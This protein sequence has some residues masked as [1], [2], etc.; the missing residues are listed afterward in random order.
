MT[1]NDFACAI[2]MTRCIA[3]ADFFFFFVYLSLRRD[4]LLHVFKIQ[5]IR[6]IWEIAKKIKQFEL[7][8]Q[9]LHNNKHVSSQ[10]IINYHAITSIT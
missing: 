9:I 5:S 10:T 4:I 3:A 6:Y 7:F 1:D 8:A 2:G